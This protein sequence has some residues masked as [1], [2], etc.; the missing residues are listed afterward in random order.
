M[1]AHASLQLSELRRR[2]F[3]EGTG[4]AILRADA[5][6][7]IHLS[8]SHVEVLEVGAWASSSSFRPLPCLGLRRE[9][10]EKREKNWDDREWQKRGKRFLEKKIL[11]KLMQ[12]GEQETMKYVS[13]H[14]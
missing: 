1:G 14:S 5:R 9:R 13:M 12:A 10:P 8:A 2:D 7:V 4:T 6:V 11:S 3:D